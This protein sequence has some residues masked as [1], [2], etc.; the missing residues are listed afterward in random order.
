MDSKGLESVSIFA[1]G[2]DHPEGI[3][4]SADGVVFAGGEAGQVYRIAL[5]GSVEVV[6]N[7]SGFN[8]G[9]CFNRDGELLIADVGNTT[10]WSWTS[11]DGLIERHRS[12]A[13]QPL[14]HPNA[15]AD[16]RHG[17]YFSD[18]G[19]WKGSNGSIWLLGLDFECRQVSTD[20]SRFPNG[21]AMSP[22]GEHLYV[23]ESNFGIVRLGVNPD[24]GLGPPEQLIALSGQVPDGIAFSPQGELYVSFYQPNLVG[25]LTDEGAWETVLYDPEAQ[26]LSM[27]T[28]I[29]F[30]PDGRLIIANLGGWHIAVSNVSALR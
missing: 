13:E 30:L 2:L 4:V 6:A 26:V 18:S 3:A 16:S 10:I 7:T 1:R 9:L 11:D 5:D 20:V 8:L 12:S 21:M 25:R 29:A 28:N 24:G 27:P 22:S 15:F 23:V 19:K 14:V 17:T